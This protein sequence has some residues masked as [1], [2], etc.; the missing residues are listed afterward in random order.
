MS[1]GFAGGSNYFG[2]AK[3]CDAYRAPKGRTAVVLTDDPRILPF[4]DQS[5]WLEN[6]RIVE[7]QSPVLADPLEVGAWE[8]TWGSPS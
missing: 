4:A 8:T 2:S 1:A 6:G 5:Q 7:R 3:G